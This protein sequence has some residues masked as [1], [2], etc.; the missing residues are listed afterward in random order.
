MKTKF[1]KKTYRDAAVEQLRINYPKLKV[2][3]SKDPHGFHVLARRLS[4][5]DGFDFDDFIEKI[6]LVHAKYVLTGSSEGIKITVKNYRGSYYP[7]R[8]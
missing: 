6:S 4:F 1:K 2:D 8:D 5:K 7:G 3:K